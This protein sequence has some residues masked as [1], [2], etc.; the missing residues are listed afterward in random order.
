MRLHHLTVSAFGPFAGTE[1]V[2]FDGLNAAGLFLLTGPTGAG[3][4]SLL[5]AVCFA[6]YGTVPGARG[7]KALKSQHAAAHVAPEVVL[8]FSVQGRRFVL[9]RTPEWSRPKKRGDGQLVEKASASIAETTGGAAH[10]LSSRAAEVGVLV[11]DLMGMSAAQFVQV[12]LLPQGEFQTFLRA[13]SQERHAVLQHLFRTDRFS[14]IEEWVDEHSRRLRAL[15]Q[16]GEV[17]VRRT[18][19]TVADRCGVACPEH[20]EGEALAPA[21]A[22][23]RALA[24]VEQ[25]CAEAAE[26]AATARQQD[27][28]A[29][30]RLE[31]TRDRQAA[32]RRLADLL[33]RRD[34]A[35]EVLRTLAADEPATRELLLRLGAHER[36]ERCGP[37]VALRRQAEEARH[38]AVVA[39]DRAVRHLDATSAG[40]VAGVSL[41]RPVTLEALDTVTEEVRTRVARLT[42]LLPRERAASR[43][44]AELGHLRSRLAEAE[45][46]LRQTTERAHR[47]PGEVDD[48]ATRLVT[49]SA[50]AARHEALALDLAAARRTLD[51]SLRLDDLAPARTALEDDRRDA[52]DGVQDARERVQRLAARRL[53]G[54]AAELAGALAEGVPCQVCGSP[55]HPLPALPAHDAVTDVEQE[56]AERELAARERALAAV[57]A[58][59]ERLRS[60]QDALRAATDGT[61]TEQSTLR[62]TRLEAGLADADAARAE[63]AVLETELRSLREEQARLASRQTESAA[64][65]ATLR[66]SVS[67]H[68]R[69]LAEVA[70]E[71]AEVVGGRHP[72]PASGP[73]IER[74]L[75]ALDTLAGDLSAARRTLVQLRDAVSHT[76]DL[77]QQ[78]HHVAQQHGFGSADE[79]EGALL[80]EAERRRLE[81][82][83]HLRETTEA[84]AFAVLESPDLDGLPD[85]PPEDLDAL[86]RL[87]AETDAAAV[88]SARV[89]ALHDELVHALLA[90]RGRLSAALDAWAPARDDSLRADSMSRLVRG[91]G[92]DNQLQMRLSAYVLATRLDQV[93][94]A[95][96]ER[97]GQLRDQRYLL[98]RTGRA[99]RR[100][101][102]AGLGLEVLDQWTGD[103]RAPSTLSGG[104]TFVVS[105]SL[106]LGLADVVTQEAGGTEIETLFVDE[107]FGTLDAD[108]LDDVMDRLDGLRAGGRTVGVVSH[109]T[110]LQSR[111]PTQVRIE[112]GRTGSTVSVRTLV[113]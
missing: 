51:A 43:V 25:R 94:A 40:S 39:H 23:G 84:R 64:T 81:E 107:G 80:P 9:R 93:V 73:G 50:R 82:S 52:R 57:D 79:V 87:V 98:Q 8:D 89:L 13:S 41:P 24:W 85:T 29:R 5:D 14:R 47:L 30:H 70:A 56:R 28:E 34:Q 48:R 38:S 106:A 59:L 91:M 77:E 99:E 69:A 36:A 7:V 27:T 6:L 72:V 113:G 71:L 22:D 44:R 4:S 54:I 76:D 35:R 86:G 78:L 15:S 104:E 17:T 63:Q 19:D 49:T 20:L 46:V 95:A 58:D 68:E 112:K 88:E 111:I 74:L 12:A 62:V 100:R 110:E 2:D 103:V 65:A 102:Q 97:L 83:R 21:A 32:G 66:Q 42:A 75:A 53:A 61:P 60:R 67:D 108:T 11:N 3:K 105:L 96:N 26:A 33:E 37:L 109:V 10:F 1:R 16:T 101:A 55:D 31:L 45:R 90:Q 92:D 18:L